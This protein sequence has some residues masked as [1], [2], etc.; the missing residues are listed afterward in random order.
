M[1]TRQTISRADESAVRQS[2]ERRYSNVRRS[3]L[4]YWTA[5]DPKAGT[6]LARRRR[7]LLGDDTSA[8]SGQMPYS[9]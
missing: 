8:I 3:K 4:G 1:S 6:I 2:L 7:L 5:T 9:K